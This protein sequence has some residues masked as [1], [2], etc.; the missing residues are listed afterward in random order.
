MREELGNVRYRT[1]IPMSDEFRHS[2]PD[3]EGGG[4]GPGWAI[5]R[6]HEGSFL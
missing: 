5:L 6:S 4:E 2:L 1:K 3:E